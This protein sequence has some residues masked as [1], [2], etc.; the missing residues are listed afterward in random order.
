M[1]ENERATLTRRLK[2]SEYNSSEKA[3]MAIPA[4]K[5]WLIETSVFNPSGFPLINY[6]RTGREKN[7]AMSWLV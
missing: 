6:Q 3:V 1:P 2:V 4:I 5:I 7:K